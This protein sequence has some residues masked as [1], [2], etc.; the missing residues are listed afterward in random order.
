MSSYADYLAQARQS[1]LSQQS[2]Y[3]AKRKQQL[4]KVLSD[5]DATAAKM[6]DATRKSYDAAL[7]ATTEQTKSLYDR[8]AIREA[9][10]RKTVAEQTANL[11]L[12]DSGL[13]RTQ[14]TAVSTARSRADAEAARTEQQAINA[15]QQELFAALA[16]NEQWLGGQKAGAEKAAESDM[17]AQLA[18]LMSQVSDNAT[19][20]YNASLSADGATGTTGGTLFNNSESAGSDL[21]QYVNLLSQ[22]DR[23]AGTQFFDNYMELVYAL[24]KR[25]IGR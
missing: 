2:D 8:N 13:N 11:G 9:V 17:Q 14:L 19:A 16:S 12:R 20:Q 25:L 4:K 6:N 18:T 15:L 22:Y 23:Y 5:L 10:A 1:A 7:A 24:R 21:Y 3:E